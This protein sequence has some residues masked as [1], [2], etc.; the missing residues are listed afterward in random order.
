MTLQ[1]EMGTKVTLHFAL[2]LEDGTVIDSNF[3]REPATFAVGDGN[4]LPGFE[5]ALIGLVDGDEKDF[6]ITPEN[7]F[8]QHNPQNVQQVERGNF[9]E[10][11]LEIGA[12]FSF[13]NGDGE[14]PGVVVELQDQ[15]IM[16]DFNHPLA[17]KAIVFKVK[18]LTISPQSVH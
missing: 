7:A 17:G 5:S 14:L 18:I 12:M 11:E 10:K 9:D 15:H 2:T 4:L 6:I 1:I 8:G 3:E 16:I 13:Q